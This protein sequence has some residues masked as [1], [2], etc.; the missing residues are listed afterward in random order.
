MSKI[1]SISIWLSITN[2]PAIGGNLYLWKPTH[3][4]WLWCLNL[5]SFLVNICKICWWLNSLILDEVESRMFDANSPWTTNMGASEIG[6]YRYTTKMAVKW[7]K[8]LQSIQFCSVLILDKPTYSPRNAV[9]RSHFWVF[10]TVNPQVC[11][12]RSNPVFLA[13]WSPDLNHQMH[14][15]N[16][17]N[18]TCWWLQYTPN[19]FHGKLGL[20][21]YAI[22]ICPIWSNLFH[23]VPTLKE[24]QKSKRH[25]KMMEK[26][27]SNKPSIPILFLASFGLNPQFAKSPGLIIF[28]G[29]H[30]AVR[31]MAS[32]QPRSS[33]T[34][35][36]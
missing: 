31:S 26:I 10:R 7:D 11:M 24:I 6:V 29:Y 25:L 27:I 4:W 35:P 18:T 3:S 9:S 33:G 19:L 14:F 36:G 20:S 23:L 16:D 8:L 1:R 12:V 2:H 22:F 28:I 30:P 17:Q 13:S 34:S 15:F 5:N 21:S 32:Y